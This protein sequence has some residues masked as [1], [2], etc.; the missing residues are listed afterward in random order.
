MRVTADLSI[1]PIGTGMSV[2]GHVAAC[3]KILKEAGLETKLHGAG[4]NVDGEWDDVFAA[5]KRC[6]EALHDD[7]TSR[8]LTTIKVETRTDR[9]QTSED[10]VES[11][12]R[13]T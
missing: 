3:E 11:V 9:D 7:D 8:L 6:H 4:T 13:K 10:K 1:T 5:V 2:S 12:R